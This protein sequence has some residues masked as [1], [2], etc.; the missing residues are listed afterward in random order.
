MTNSKV[1]IFSSCA[2]Y[3][4]YTPALALKKDMASIGVTSE[5]F[6]FE[7]FF[8]EEQ[9][10]QFLMYRKQFH[11]DFRFAAM[12]TGIASKNLH[13]TKISF[14]SEEIRLNRFNKYI[15]LYGL[16]LP[17]LLQQGIDEEKIVCLQLDVEESPSWHAVR[18]FSANCE[19]IW[20]IGKDGE[21]PKYKF[22]DMGSGA[23]D[24]AVV[25]HGGGWGI[26]NYLDILNDIKNEYELHVI[27]SSVSECSSEYHS[28]FTPIN[29]LPDKRKL[30]YPPLKQYPE[31]SAVDFYELCSNCSGIIS[32]PGG[33]T[34]ADS[35]RFCTPL[36]YLQ[37]MAKH[38]EKNAQHF[39]KLGYACSFDE[40]KSTGF[41]DKKLDCISKKIAADMAGVELISHYLSK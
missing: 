37:G 27:H 17:V 21:K 10:D 20:M 18:E 26:R 6:V 1:A 19:N 31:N 16:W 9:K 22:R 39:S 5:I 40:W 33:G 11:S 7:T 8:A 41:S 36:V 14:S 34:C 4:T 12:A 25:I 35:L 3:G 13:N 30:D 29:W 24:K 2:G 23:V 28:Y 38:E 15:V 32:K